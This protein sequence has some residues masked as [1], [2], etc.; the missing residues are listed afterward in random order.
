MKTQ[1]LGFQCLAAESGIRLLRR[2]AAGRCWSILI[3]MLLGNTVLGLSGCTALPHKEFKAYRQAFAE[4]RNA[5]APL[6]NDLGLAWRAAADADT[7]G[8][9]ADDDW[10]KFDPVAP[11]TR[12]SI[13]DQVLLRHQAWLVTERYNDALAA[14]A[15][16]RSPHEIEGLITGFLT[17]VSDLPLRRLADVA[18]GAHPLTGMIR[19]AMVLIEREVEARQFHR[20]VEAGGPLVDAMLA[21]MQDE[22]SDHYALRLVLNTRARRELEGIVQIELIPAFL[23]IYETT[24][25]HEGKAALLDEL[26]AALRDHFRYR[27]AQLVE[28]N[29]DA[30]LP[31]PSP[32]ELALLMSITGEVRSLGTQFAALREELLHYQDVLHAYYQLLDVARHRMAV[33]REAVERGGMVAADDVLLSAVNLYWQFTKYQNARARR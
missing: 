24:G 8:D 32:S 19:E 29:D 18:A 16:G 21:M 31:P 15:E 26:N 1:R 22:I 11:R 25:A 7:P 33:L 30:S 9:G 5:S 23:D 13:D 3:A 20:A 14:L 27:E 2:P 10:E 17:S 4:A 28:A 12:M 6:I